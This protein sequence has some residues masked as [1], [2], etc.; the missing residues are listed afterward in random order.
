MDAI[1]GQR[2]GDPNASGPSRAQTELRWL[3]SE[4]WPVRRPYPIDV[5]CPVCGAP[6][7]CDFF[8]RQRC[9]G[10]H[11]FG[12][13]AFWTGRAS[14]CWLFIEDPRDG[15]LLIYADAPL[16]WRD[17]GHRVV[18]AAPVAATRAGPPETEALP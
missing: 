13:R 16:V 9:P 6:T 10:G 2:P 11:T 8:G 5:A 3:D 7:R 15:E 1:T 18:V 4:L 14:A 17:D 12:Q